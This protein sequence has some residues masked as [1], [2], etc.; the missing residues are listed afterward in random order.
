M[1]E[2]MEAMGRLSTKYKVEKDSK[3]NEKLV[4]FKGQPHN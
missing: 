3:S 1:D 2:A 4:T